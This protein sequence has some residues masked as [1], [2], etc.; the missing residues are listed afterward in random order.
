MW[1]TYPPWSHLHVESDV[2]P[3]RSKPAIGRVADIRYIEFGIVLMTR[4]MEA[5]LGKAYSMPGTV[6]QLG[7]LPPGPLGRADLGRSGRLNHEAHT[8]VAIS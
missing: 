5:V 1:N 6:R 3:R 4:E 8:R 2:D 7:I